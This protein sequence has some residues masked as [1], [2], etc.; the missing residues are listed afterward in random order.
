MEVGVLFNEMEA[1]SSCVQAACSGVAASA[2]HEA[3]MEVRATNQRAASEFLSSAQREVAEEKRSVRARHHQQ[4]VGVAA[5]ETMPTS[6]PE[7]TDRCDT[8]ALEAASAE[9]RYISRRKTDAE[10]DDRLTL[11]ELPAPTRPPSIKARP[12]SW[13]SN[14]PSCVPGPPVSIEQLFNQGVCADIQRTIGEVAAAENAVK[15]GD[16]HRP[17]FGRFPEVYVARLCQPEW[18][19]GYVWGTRDPANCVPVAPFSL[20]DPPVHDLCPQFFGEWGR[21]LSW[22]D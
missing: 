11:E 22:P 10:T 2:L 12:V 21:H 3:V 9:L 4:V 16:P 5:P 6:W 8:S 17:I 18:A 20:E 1:N 7:R 15:R 13:D 19:R 14:W